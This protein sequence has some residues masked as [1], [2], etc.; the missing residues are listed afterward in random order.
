MPSA[1][2]VKLPN[3]ITYLITSGETAT[4]PATEDFASLL[5][6]L[7]AAVAAGVSLIQLREKNLSARQLYELTLL[8][9]AITRGSSTR[10]LVNERADIARAAGA[11]GVH[12]PARSLDAATVRATFGADFLI[13]VSTHSV[14][15]VR[16]ARTAEADFVVFGPV[17][18]SPSKTIYGA[19]LGLGK[20]QAAAAECAPF[21]VIALGGIDQSGAAD[22][23]RAGASGIAAIRLFSES[24][25]LEQ[26][27]EALR[28]N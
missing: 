5:N 26:V 19:P 15:E 20:L 13:G 27:V 23:L 22:C 16:A 14:A 17:F 9:V 3:P 25:K 10:L 21:P 6:L 12:L 1:I 7:S 11:D 2:P 24:G 4:A 18:Q 8:A 28:Q